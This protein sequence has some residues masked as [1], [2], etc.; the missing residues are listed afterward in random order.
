MERKIGVAASVGLPLAVTLI[1]AV[2]ELT[3]TTVPAEVATA[4][5]AV[6]TS[7]LGWLTPQPK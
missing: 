1:W 7:A 2:Q 5:G 4:F 3:G 6:L